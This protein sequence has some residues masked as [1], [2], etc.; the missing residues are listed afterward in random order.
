[1]DPKDTPGE[2]QPSQPAPESTPPGTPGEAQPSEQAA[3]STPPDDN[4]G[5][6]GAEP[7]PPGTPGEAQPSEGAPRIDSGAR[8]PS[9][10]EAERGRVVGAPEFTS[11][12]TPIASAASGG[13][14]CLTRRFPPQ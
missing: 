2:P 1:M 7:T 10:G 5:D 11:G 14:M 6:R 9:R 8:R 13:E 3:E 4:P 12:A